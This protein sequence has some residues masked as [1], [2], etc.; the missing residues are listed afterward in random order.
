MLFLSACTGTVGI[1]AGPQSIAQVDS[2]AL[3]PIRREIEEECLRVPRVSTPA[4]LGTG[5][6]VQQSGANAGR[7]AADGDFN[8]IYDKRRRNQLLTAFLYASDLSYARY[9]RQLLNIMRQ[10]ALGASTLSIMLST[11]ASTIEGH[12]DLVR[13]LSAANTVVTGTQAAIG[14]DYLMNQTLQ[15]MLSQMRSNR[16]RQ[17]ALILGRLGNDID[18]YPICVALSDALAFEQAGTMVEALVRTT[19]TVAAE[20]RQNAER[21]RQA[22]PTVDLA[23]TTTAVALD[24]FLYPDD[25]SLWQARSTRVQAIIG[26]EN[27]LATPGMM[28]GERMRRIVTDP[29]EAHEQDRRLIIEKLIA[30][31]DVEDALKEPL[32]QSLVQPQ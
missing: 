21:V 31:P 18:T 30:S 10:D 28:I 22:I 32:R 13:S 19:E 14:R 27:L 4:A 1:P 17:R 6:V 7:P 24:H 2:D 5:G 11:L 8:N 9:E 29:G 23:R 26:S 20:G 15:L 12:A 16:A 3:G 25:R